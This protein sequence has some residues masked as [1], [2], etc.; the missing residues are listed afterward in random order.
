MDGGGETNNINKYT[1]IINNNAAN[2]G[3]GVIVRNSD[4]DFQNCII[5][6]NISGGSGSAL[7]I[8]KYGGG[9]QDGG[10]VNLSDCLISNNISSGNEPSIYATDFN[11]SITNCTIANN[12]GAIWIDQQ[13]L[14]SQLNII[15][16][17]I[18]N[19]GELIM[20]GDLA[21]NITYSNIQG[22]WN[23][24]GNINANPYFCYGEYTLAE[25]SP[26]VGTGQD[27]ANM[28]AFGVGCEAHIPILHVAT[29]GSDDNDGM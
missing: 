1:Y 28:G 25:N 2:Y 13:D 17:I 5:I 4:V 6:N 21:S 15:N 27:G 22:G 26:C 23:G 12:S 24:E 8:T 14:E 16:T 20:T 7:H 10:T 11:L 19:S 3:G 9:N 29:T 18:W